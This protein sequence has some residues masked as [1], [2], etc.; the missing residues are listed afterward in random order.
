MVQVV[1]CQSAEPKFKSVLHEK[2][3]KR[4]HGFTVFGLR[5][6][7]IYHIVLSVHSA[8]LLLFASRRLKSASSG[9]VR[10]EKDWEKDSAA[11]PS[12]CVNK[13]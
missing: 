2:I 1:V 11:R 5:R 3:E 9:V 12:A 10:V 6:E 7:D 8:A 13:Q 4:R